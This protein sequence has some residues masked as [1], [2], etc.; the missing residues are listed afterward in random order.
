MPPTITEPC[1]KAVLPKPCIKVNKQ[2][3]CDCH[4]D[5]SRQQ[6]DTERQQGSHL[7]YVFHELYRKNL[8]NRQRKP[9]KWSY[10]ITIRIK[11]AKFFKLIT[12]LRPQIT[13][14]DMQQK[15][16]MKHYSPFGTR[17]V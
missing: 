10:S 1:L 7:Q 13:K 15:H 12:L 14:Q 5:T 17:P 9:S 2:T 8:Q 4:T 3:P 16:F 11:V 6:L